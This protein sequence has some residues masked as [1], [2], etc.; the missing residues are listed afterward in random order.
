MRNVLARTSLTLA[1]LLAGTSAAAQSARA[2]VEVEGEL[3]VV[4]DYRFR[5]YSL[6]DH[7]PAVQGGLTATLA[8]GLY[9]SAWGSTIDEVGAG[10]DGHGA[11]V[12]LDLALGWAGSL[13]GLD[14]DVSAQA[15]TYP[16]GHD[17]SYVELPV[18]ASRAMGDWRW[19]VG[20]AYAPSQTALGHQDN[21]YGWVGLD[22]SR[23]GAPVALHATAGYEDGAF[24]P[25]GKWD[26][27]VGV[28]RDLG[29]LTAG[30]TYVDS[31]RTGAAVVAALTA[32]F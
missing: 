11:T 31:G 21:T 30:L 25:G 3:G 24:A 20:A 23:E 32:R 2:P 10:A 17:V 12:E 19:T 26:W 4:S 6:S 16:G 27:A 22:W 15:Y 7:D 28:S 14:I 29:P 1:A 5:G 18:S 8:G 9:G 13:G